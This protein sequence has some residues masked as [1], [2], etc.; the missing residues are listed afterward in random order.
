MSDNREQNIDMKLEVQTRKLTTVNEMIIYKVIYICLQQTYCTYSIGLHLKH[1]NS[2]C[3]Q[4]F[5][6]LNELTCI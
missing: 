2:E 3:R 4:Q 6:S 1:G 5:R